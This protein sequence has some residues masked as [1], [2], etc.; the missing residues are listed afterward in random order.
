MLSCHGC[1]RQC[2]QT[3]ICDYAFLSSPF[4]RTVAIQRSSQSFRR[5]YSAQPTI[6]DRDSYTPMKVREPLP[7]E[8]AYS[9]NASK[10]TDHTTKRQQ[11]LESRGTTPAHKRNL[12]PSN[13]RKH[14]KY[15][16]D[17]LKLAEDIRRLLRDDDL[18]SALEIVRAASKDVQCTVSWNH[19]IDWQ[20]SKG[21]LNAAV[22]TYNE[23]RKEVFKQYIRGL[24]HRSRR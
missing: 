9:R 10:E 19:V 7:H 24:T 14:L 18:Q 4:R 21:R 1:R 2:L 15:L 3:L 17:P 20:M 13:M 11:W 12:E 22:K 6:D 23:V 16:K 5:T 8:Y